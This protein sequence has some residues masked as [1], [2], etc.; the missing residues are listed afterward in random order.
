MLSAQNARALASGIVDFALFFSPRTA[1][2]F[3]GLAERAGITP[4]LSAVTAVSISTAA[5]AALAPTG[6]RERRVADLPT[7]AALL[8]ALD[9]L[10][11]ERR[12]T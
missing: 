11:A 8:S 12:R 6:F 5:D 10:V 1:A 7:Q 3:V 4:A 9:C 2:I